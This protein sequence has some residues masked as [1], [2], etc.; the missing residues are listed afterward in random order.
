MD[1]KRILIAFDSS[2]ASFKAVHY[3]G[4]MLPEI[5]SIMVTLLFV[6]RLPDEDFYDTKEAWCH[7]CA[8]RIE[9]YKQSLTKARK[10][11]EQLGLAPEKIEENT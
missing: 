4:L 9:S 8:K 7:E 11:L 3:A 1:N 6:E 5:P 10:H 2:D